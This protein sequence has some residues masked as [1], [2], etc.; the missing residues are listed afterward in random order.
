M[1]APS[2]STISNSEAICDTPSPWTA[3]S[4][5]SRSATSTTTRAGSTAISG[6]SADRNT[7]MSRATTKMMT[8]HWTCPPVLLEVA[9]VSTRVATGPAVCAASPV[10]S[11]AARM[12]SRRPA[13]RLACWEVARPPD[14]A[15]VASTVSCSA[16]P[17]ADCPASRTAVTLAARASAADNRAMAAW[18]A[19]VNA[20]PDRAAT[21]VTAV[22]EAP[23]SGEAS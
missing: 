11:A 9:L 3:A 4:A 1:P 6:A 20:P 7:A 8:N 17:S 2:T 13:T 21:T 15:S 12:T 10:G 19:P 23:C 5:V 16:R 18:S 22:S 14:W